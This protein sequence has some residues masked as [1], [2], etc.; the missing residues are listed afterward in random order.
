VG[1][2]DSQISLAVA[3]VIETSLGPS[4]YTLQRKS[5]WYR[6]LPNTPR[7]YIFAF[8]NAVFNKNSGNLDLATRE[9]ISKA[10]VAEAVMVAAALRAGGGV[11]H[12]WK[13]M[14][15]IAEDE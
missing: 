2:H 13:A 1:T 10:D 3:R 15:S 8:D 14:K 5:T 9:L 6:L 12:G 11:T 7:G 4:S